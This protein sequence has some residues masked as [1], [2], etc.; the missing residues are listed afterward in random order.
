MGVG[1][2]FTIFV[3]V[4]VGMHLGCGLRS[5]QHLGLR[6][7]M[8]ALVPVAVRMPVRRA[9]RVVVW[10]RIGRRC[11]VGWFH[12][13]LCFHPEN[14]RQSVSSIFCSG[15]MCKQL[16]WRWF[17]NKSASMFA[18]QCAEGAFRM[19]L[20]HIGYVYSGFNSDV[21]CYMKTE[22]RMCMCMQPQSF[23]L[24]G[25]ASSSSQEGV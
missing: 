8:R 2:C 1:M 23:L 9:V 20:F 4:R 5:R 21:Y 15:A 3:L 6:M 22:I 14:S 25:V 16:S 24:S 13:H 11:G 7:H 19:E 10:W 18:V 12:L 17:K